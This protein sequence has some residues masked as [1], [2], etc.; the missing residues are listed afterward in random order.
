MELGSS[1][2][3]NVFLIWNALYVSS[4]IY[5]T[6]AHSGNT[7]LLP[8]QVTT[9]NSVYSYPGQTLELKCT[10]DGNEDVV[11]WWQTPFGLFK[12]FNHPN[13]DPVETSNGSL[14][15]SKV[16]SSHDG[17][18]FC[19]RQDETGRTISPFRVNVVGV[20]PNIKERLR[21]NR[22]AEVYDDRRVTEGDFVA[23]VTSSVI[24]TFF[25]AFTLG[26]FSRSYVIKCLKV[27]MA[28]MPCTKGR[29]NLT[30][31]NDDLEPTTNT[32][33]AEFDRVHFYINPDT[34]EDTVDIV[35][36]R[37]HEDSVNKESERQDDVDATENELADGMKDDSN[38]LQ[39][40][41]EQQQEFKTVLSPHPKKKM[42]VIKVYNYDED[43]N[44][45]GH[46]KDSEVE[47]ENE[48]RPRLRTKS[49][50]RLD[51]IMKEAEFTDFKP[52]KESTD[53]QSA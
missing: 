26:A 45:Y 17:L 32:Q 23:A 8:L 38:Q 14:R 21:K 30:S 12:D 52:V 44:R 16:T 13:K 53:S 39:S 15:I 18:Y 5:K 22:K 1:S 10:H 31:G 24:V 48:V 49:L 33:P 35:G 51:A 19:V 6:T 4:F 27:T 43:G 28:R 36:S 42:R 9:I 34:G 40:R 2:L 25:V 41:E 7:K 29:H 47:G 46:I 50:T 37:M 20:N 3:L 11:H